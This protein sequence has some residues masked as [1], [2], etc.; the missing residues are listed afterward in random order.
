MLELCNKPYC[1]LKEWKIVSAEP[2][3][4][5]R[6]KPGTHINVGID[7]VLVSRFLV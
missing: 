6:E 7:F 3:S 2:T 5:S 1:N 4:I